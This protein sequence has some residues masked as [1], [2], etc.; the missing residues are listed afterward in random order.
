MMKNGKNERTNAK[1]RRDIGQDGD[2]GQSV[3]RYEQI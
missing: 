1:K 2:S 3:G